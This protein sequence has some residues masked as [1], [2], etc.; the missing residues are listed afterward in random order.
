MAKKRI[1]N[2]IRNA[3]YILIQTYSTHFYYHIKLY[4]VGKHTEGGEVLLL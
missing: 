4:G 2:H 3:F 1:L